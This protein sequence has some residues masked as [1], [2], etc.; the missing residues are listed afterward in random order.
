MPVALRWV[1]HDK[2][3]PLTWTVVS[4]GP[5]SGKGTQCERIVER[6]GFTHLSSGDLLR[7]EV[8]GKHHEPVARSR[9]PMLRDELCASPKSE[10]GIKIKAIMDRGE[11]VPLVCALADIIRSS[12]SHWSLRWST[13]GSWGSKYRLNK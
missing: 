12:Y 5:G 7:D 10:L 4:G 11:L 8:S 9:C 6:Y 1:S 13:L 3:H 2:A